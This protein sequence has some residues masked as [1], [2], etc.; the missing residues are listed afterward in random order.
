MAQDVE[1]P[2]EHTRTST[3]IA[4][5][6]WKR[7]YGREQPPFT[8][9][10][11]FTALG[12]A[13]GGLLEEA[14]LAT[15]CPINLS[16][17]QPLKRV[18]SLDTI[19]AELAR[20]LGTPA[21]ELGSADVIDIFELLEQAIASKPEK[22]AQYDDSV[23][24]RSVLANCRIP[25]KDNR[26][27]GDFRFKSRFDMPI[28][29]TKSLWHHLNISSSADKDLRIPISM[30][31]FDS[32]KE[33]NKN[34]L[35]TIQ[36]TKEFIVSKCVE[37]LDA[38]ESLVRLILDIKTGAP[39]PLDKRSQV[40]LRRGHIPCLKKTVY[41]KLTDKQRLWIILDAIER[42]KFYESLPKYGHFLR[43]SGIKTL[44][45][46]TA[47]ITS[48]RE[49][50]TVALS[51]YYL[52]RL[53]VTACSILLCI[54]CTW[55]ADTLYSLT[56]EDIVPTKNGYLLLGLKGRG[57]QEQS[58][59][60]EDLKSGD[61]ESENVSDEPD[62]IEV[63]NAQAIR[64][65]KLLLVNHQ[66]IR[67]YTKQENPH[68]F[69]SLN[70]ANRVDSLF[71]YGIQDEAIKDFCKHHNLPPLNFSDLRDIASHAEYLRPGGDIYHVNSILNHVHLATTAGYLHSTIID[72]LC[73]ANIL[74]FMK[75]LQASILFACGRTDLLKKKGIPDKFID[76]DLLFPISPLQEESE[77][78]L[79]DK[80]LASDG[81][82]TL[83][84]GPEEIH[85]CALQYAY[86]RDNFAALS[87]S[88][89]ERFVRRHLPRIVTCVALRNVIQA[90]T[91]AA[92]L[93]QYEEKYR[94][95]SPFA[96]NPLRG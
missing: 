93:S 36:K 75:K 70:S 87:A 60:I 24:A 42:F 73:D 96:S 28:R 71:V 13:F 50:L 26:R 15:E 27:I 57:N 85:H 14:L 91:H 1:T 64:A 25:L 45:P 30:Q 84:I 10:F 66:R 94:E 17:I 4:M 54:E 92:L 95:P 77:T 51:D 9:F 88:A 53:A 83:A 5:A 63:T 59:H 43:L 23:R 74:R 67:L 80:W 61:I 29:G 18:L 19:P 65:I 2:L 11:D 12:I 55:N 20:Y 41:S 79:I 76:K 37:T 6:A 35:T 3:G 38:H 44:Y 56:P 68:L 16:T 90:S 82:I 72:A 69:A 86:Y 52:P 22:L 47:D 81:T 89:P 40:A 58:C 21:K 49:L 39:A 34:A 31:D 62:N 46:L 78:S 8:V 33:R 32:L 7:L 48:N